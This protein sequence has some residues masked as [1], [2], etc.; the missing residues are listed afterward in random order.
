[1]AII[2]A[3]DF[4]MNEEV[5]EGIRYCFQCGYIN[6]T[7]LMVNGQCVREALKISVE[8]KFI[9]HVGLHLNLV[10]GEPLTEDIKQTHLC[11][12]GLLNGCLMKGKNRF[13]LD[14]STRLAVER[15]LE[16]QI[17]KYL[18][19]GFTLK[20]LDS[21]RHSHTN[22]SIVNI[23]EKLMKKYQFESLRL[24][25][26]AS[27]GKATLKKVYKYFINKKIRH[28]NSGGSYKRIKYFGT[29]EDYLTGAC[30]KDGFE[31]MVHPIM[32]GQVLLDNSS[33]KMLESMLIHIK[34]NDR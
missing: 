10:S 34:G 7:T 14:K 3:D 31:V 18:E 12:E 13:F 16:A 26:N 1:M 19:L 2:N 21:H 20:H 6:Q 33:K 17:N 23:V 25:R 5:N 11:D 22:Y 30:R 9:D 32:K 29:V 24:C 8:D 27:S 28:I 15:E 4:G